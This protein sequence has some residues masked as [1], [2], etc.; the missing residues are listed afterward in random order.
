[1]KYFSDCSTIEEVKSLYKQLA[2]VLHPDCG[3][4]TELM[5]ELN[6][7]YDKVC[8]FILKES[9]FTNEQVNEEMKVSGEYRKVIEFI[10]QLEGIVIELIGNWIWVSGNTYPVKEALKQAG[11]HYSPQKIAWYYH[12]EGYNGRNSGKNLDEIREK[13]G[14]EKIK[15]GYSGPMLY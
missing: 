11:M 2:K 9:A 6:S 5:Q 15:S 13:Y 12:P 7:E 14:S 3:G 1:M 10:I 4:S 8:A